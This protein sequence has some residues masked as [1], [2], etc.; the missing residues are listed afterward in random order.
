MKN[1]QSIW[2]CKFLGEN[3]NG[4]QEYSAPTEYKLRFNYLTVNPTSN[5]WSTEQYGEKLSKMW[6]MTAK[7]KVFENIFTEGDLLYIEGCTPNTSSQ[8][9]VNGDGANAIIKSVLPYY[10]SMNISL[11]RIEP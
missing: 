2:H 5:F 6:S 11:E 7:R 9:Y 10:L 3:E 8:G 1:R 4:V